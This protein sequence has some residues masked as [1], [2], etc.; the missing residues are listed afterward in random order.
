MKKLD[1]R[2][3]FKSLLTPPSKNVVM[4][5]VARYQFLMI[6]GRGDPNTS[7]LFQE[8]IQAL[9]ALSYGLKF[10]LKKERAVDYPVMP[11]EGLFSGEGVEW[12]KANRQ[13]W[14]WT[15]MILQPGV[16]TKTWVERIRALTLEKGKAPAAAR[17]RF[18]PYREGRSVQIMHIGPYSAEGPTIARLHDYMRDNG[19]IP[20]GRHHEIY[21]GDPRRS[22]P[23]KLRTVVRQPIRKA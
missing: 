8:S 7:P 10:T 6:D 17:V 14:R 11:I 21:L 12:F 15:L 23:E 22:A 20:N 19:W 5:Q 16:V 18:E 13:D 2:K 9:Y 4:V 3:E 1:L